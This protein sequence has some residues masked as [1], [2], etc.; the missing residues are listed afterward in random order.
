M[1]IFKRKKAEPDCEEELLM[2][3]ELV[4]M[5]LAENETLKRKLMV[6]QMLAIT[7][8]DITKINNRKVH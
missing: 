3:N 7:P 6:Y 1:R 2:A 8:V 4:K 5:L